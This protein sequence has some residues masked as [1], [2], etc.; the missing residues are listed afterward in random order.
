[1][2]TCCPECKTC[3]RITDEQL[4]MAKGLVR[5]G[6]CHQVF[7]GSESL[8][9]T[10]P[11]EKL[12]S[13]ASD[14]RHEADEHDSSIFAA[15]FSVP[16]NTRPEHAQI[17][18]EDNILSSPGDHFNLPSFSAQDDFIDT[19]VQDQV[20]AEDAYQYSDISDA[21]K[22][23]QNIDDIF[24]DMHQQLELGMAEL[25][26]NQPEAGNLDDLATDNNNRNT[27]KEN[28]ALDDELEIN[29][30]IDNIFAE[31]DH[32]RHDDKHDDQEY[33]LEKEMLAA[34]GQHAQLDSSSDNIK[35]ED[36]AISI[37]AIPRPIDENQVASPQK[38]SE[39][40]LPRRL[41]DSLA[42]PEPKKP[43]LW[44]TIAGLFLILLLSLAL[45]IQLAL[46]RSI[47]II[48][49]IP[50][51]RPWLEQFCQYAPCRI[52]ARK[53]ID[54]IRILERDIRANPQD[55]KALLITATIVNQARFS[56]AYPDIRVTL[57]DLTGS[58]VAQRRFSSAD[59][60]GKLNSPFLL[61]KP[62]IPVHIRI[63]VL[64]PGRD[65]VNFEF[66]FL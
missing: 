27:K 39:D 23:E 15:E 7:N 64:D 2:F 63:A 35:F 61:M 55:K 57:S 60:L 34:F 45:L 26:K 4:A 53:D 9:E 16:E 66:Q 52:H 33:R 31:S 11:D 25:E 59:Y 1:M 50:Q 41:R 56:Q 38:P 10:L 8:T 12:T 54:K 22:E 36:E 49:Y 62:G 17:E 37:T 18:T 5:C 65:A 51:A 29:Q 43:R 13:P 21:L 58:V 48:Q 40:E 46:F 44:K 30:A 6:H 28:N 42:V 47:D 24:S 19:F 20:A 14:N 32:P 3:F